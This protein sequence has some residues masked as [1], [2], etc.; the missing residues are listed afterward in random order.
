MEKD[1]IQELIRK[2]FALSKSPNEH[3]AAL[4]L[5]KALELCRK[6]NVDPESLENEVVS[7]ETY[8]SAY[9][10]VTVDILFGYTERWHHELFH[11]IAKENFCQAI[12]HHKSTGDILSII[13]RLYNIFATEE[14]GKWICAQVDRITEEEC[15]R[16]GIRYRN[17]FKNG[18]AQRLIYRIREHHSKVQYG[19][20]SSIMEDLT[21]ETADWV[22]KNIPGLRFT[23]GIRPGGKGYSAGYQAG[24][25]V[26]VGV[27]EKVGRGTGIVPYR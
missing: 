5:E 26:Q 7:D 1:D 10:H 3:E 27:G 9:S 23:G 20:G 6:F 8:M 11:A 4:A 24:D 12:M 18:M 2:C 15:G 25:R 13:G 21:K 16:K 14:M 22:R 19:T 17:S